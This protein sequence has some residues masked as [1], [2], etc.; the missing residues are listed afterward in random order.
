MEPTVYDTDLLNFNLEAARETYEYLRAHPERHSQ[1]VFVLALDTE[2]P[3]GF[4]ETHVPNTDCGTVGCIAGTVTLLDVGVGRVDFHSGV[5]A[6]A[7]PLRQIY[8]IAESKFGS[9][10]F[11]DPITSSSVFA[12]REDGKKECIS[13]EDYARDRL[14]LGLLDSIQ[15]FF[16]REQ[17]ASFQR[18]WT[19]DQ[20]W[21][22][23][24]SDVWG[25]WTNSEFARIDSEADSL[26]TLAYFIERAE[27]AQKEKA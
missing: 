25:Y 2:S 19:E 8:G 14:G 20:E 26:D 27:E 4:N 11:A 16:G 18:T 5:Y 13:I 9:D 10:V 1:Q 23:D 7:V 15:I 3:D 12:H 21:D 24:M 6:G 22:D 17:S